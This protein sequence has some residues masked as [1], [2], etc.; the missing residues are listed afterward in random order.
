VQSVPIT[1]KVVSSNPVHGEVYSIQHYVIKFVS[2]LQQVFDFFWVLCLIFLSKYLIN[3]N[4][5]GLCCLTAL[6][7]IFQ[8]Y[9]GSQFYWLRKP[10]Y[11]EKIKD[12]LQFTDKLY[13]IMLYRVHLARAEFELTTLVVICTYYC[14]SGATY[15]P[16]NCCFSELAL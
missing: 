9:C 16:V 7:T 8:L 2:E 1:T 5:G 13:H 11:P 12:L 3:N 4:K 14:Q 10:E 15:L 6:S